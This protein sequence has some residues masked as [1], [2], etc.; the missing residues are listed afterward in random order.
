MLIFLGKQYLGQSDDKGKKEQMENFVFTASIGD[1]GQIVQ[2]IKNASDWEKQKQ[3]PIKAE[4]AKIA[5]EAEDKSKSKQGKK[6]LAK[7]KPRKKVKG[8]KD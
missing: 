7:A 1:S 5:A 8:K 3:Y 2:S 4:L 6:K